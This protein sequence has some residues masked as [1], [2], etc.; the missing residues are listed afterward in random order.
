M[1]SKLTAALRDVSVALGY[2]EIPIFIQLPK[3]PNHGDF[4]SNLAMQLSGKLNENPLEI[5]QS[6]VKKRDFLFICQIS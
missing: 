4:S 5:A 3:N 6:I 1:K 2:P